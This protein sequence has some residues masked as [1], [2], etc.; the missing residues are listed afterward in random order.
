M[1]AYWVSALDLH[2][3]PTDSRNVLVVLK[4]EAQSELLQRHNRIVFLE[5]KLME[6]KETLK[7]HCADNIQ[8]SEDS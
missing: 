2:E 4:N 6:L 1:K 8:I 3:F 7:S 5:N